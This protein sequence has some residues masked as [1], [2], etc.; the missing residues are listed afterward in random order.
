MKNHQFVEFHNIRSALKTIC[1]SFP[2]LMIALNLFPSSNIFHVAEVGNF[3][4][5][6]EIHST[7]DDSDEST[8][9]NPF[10]LINALKKA[11]SMDEATSP[12]D[13]IDQ[14]LKGFDSEASNTFTAETTA[15]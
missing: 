10:Q 7:F 3:N 13:A 9:T 14:A 15:P 6:K 2:A 12:T 8:I 1:I 11:S 4:T 5:D